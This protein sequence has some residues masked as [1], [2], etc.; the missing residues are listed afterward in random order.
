M[1]QCLVGAEKRPYAICP[2]QR[3][4]AY[5]GLC[6]PAGKSRAR[7]AFPVRFRACAVGIAE[8]DAFLAFVIGPRPGR[9]HD[10]PLARNKRLAARGPLPTGNANMPK[11]ERRLSSLNDCGTGGGSVLAS[12][13]RSIIWVPRDCHEHAAVIGVFL[14][15]FE[16]EHGVL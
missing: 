16:A 7:R 2:V 4:S 5:P 9:E 10:C 11:S 3:L 8:I 6:D 14:Q 12:G 15:D 13:T 1:V